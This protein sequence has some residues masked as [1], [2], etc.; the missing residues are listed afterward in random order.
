MLQ[1]QFCMFNKVY[2]YTLSFLTAHE[3]MKVQAIRIRSLLLVKTI[4]H[5]V[6]FS[7]AV[8]LAAGCL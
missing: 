3:H 5:A 4:M 1:M 2:F 8:Y 7:T 6:Q